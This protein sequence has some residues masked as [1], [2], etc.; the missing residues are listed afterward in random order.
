MESLPVSDPRASIERAGYLYLW[1]IRKRTARVHIENP[2]TGRAHCQAENCGGK[3]F[4][5]KGAEIPPGRR[6]CLNCADLAGR[7]ETDCQEPDVRVL[8][9]ERLPAL[10]NV[11][12]AAHS[13]KPLQR[14]KQARP[15]HRSKGHRPKRSNVKYHKPFD[16]P[17]PW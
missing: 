3:A 9:G 2:K 17:L 12:L 11:P 4:D 7:I 13:P 6:L 1:R 14:R 15:A 5:G 16:D 10:P 8:M